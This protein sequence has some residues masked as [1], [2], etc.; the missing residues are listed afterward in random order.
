M[1]YQPAFPRGGQDARAIRVEAASGFDDVDDVRA[2]RAEE[3]GDGQFVPDVNAEGGDETRRVTGCEVGLAL[4][5][6]QLVDSRSEPGVASRNAMDT[7]SAAVVVSASVGPVKWASTVK[8][9][10]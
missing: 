7:A 8:P 5:D 4:P 9:P 10:L 2:F 6:G 1:P 3:A